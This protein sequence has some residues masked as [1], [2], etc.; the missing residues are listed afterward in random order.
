MDA[1]IMGSFDRGLF[2]VSGKPAPGIS[3]EKAEAA[4]NDQIKQISNTPPS[5]GELQKVKNKIESTLVFSRMNVLDKAINLAYAEL[6]GD[7]DLVNHEAAKYQSVTQEKFIETAQ[8]VFRTD[9]CSTLI[10]KSKNQKK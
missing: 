7:A 4:I 1:F 9:N 10:Y 3:I 6:L 8:Q 5:T 2:V